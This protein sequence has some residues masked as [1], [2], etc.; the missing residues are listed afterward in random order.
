MLA[1]Q[2]TP[3]LKRQLEHFKIGRRTIPRKMKNAVDKLSEDEIEAL[4]HFY[5]SNNLSGK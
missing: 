4:L 2:W 5:A 3:Y 1:G